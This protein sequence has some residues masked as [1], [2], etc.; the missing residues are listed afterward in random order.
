[1]K[2]I[3]LFS[4]ISLLIFS[5]CNQ[6]KKTTPL[7]CA[8]DTRYVEGKLKNLTGFDGCGWVIALDDST[9]LEPVNLA[10]FTLQKSEGMPV[11]CCY[12]EVSAASICMVGKTVQLA[13]I[14]RTTPNINCDSAICTMDY[15]TISL[16]INYVSVPP[17]DNR[18]T[19]FKTINTATGA[20]INEKTNITAADQDLYALYGYPVVSDGQLPQGTAEMD[21]T[22]IGYRNGTEAVRTTI[23]AGHDCCHIFKV[24]GV[25]EVN[26]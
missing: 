7:Q 17:A 8:A 25:S 16:K 5:A 14:R 24:S 1:M 22:F 12:K 21:I 26:L 3:I 15:R 6:T 23:Q 13:D 9:V 18:I 20:V 19:S 4:T 11:Q 10:D 2:K